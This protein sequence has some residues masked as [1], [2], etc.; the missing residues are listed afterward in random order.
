MTAPVSQ[1]GS[2]PRVDFHLMRKLEHA[3]KRQPLRFP[4]KSG[5]PVWILM[6]WKYSENTRTRA[7]MSSTASAAST[8]LGQVVSHHQ[9]SHDDMIDTWLGASAKIARL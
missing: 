5:K 7:L 8:Q 4:V 2:F 9:A 1:R 6:D 3:E